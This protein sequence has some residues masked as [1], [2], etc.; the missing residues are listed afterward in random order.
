MTNIKK[1]IAIA[2]LK[3]Q[4]HAPTIMTIA[5]ITG[6]VAGTVLA[7]KATVKASD[8]KSKLEVELEDINNEDQPTTE[9]DKEKATIE[10]Y[11]I[12]IVDYAKLY[13]PAAAVI[14]T[15]AASIVMANRIQENHKAALGATLASTMSTFKSYRDRVKERYGEEAEKS[16]FFN[17]NRETIEETVEDENG[18]TKTVQTEANVTDSIEYSIYARPFDELCDGWCRDARL[19]LATI[20]SVQTWA[21]NRLHTHGFLFLNEVYEAFGMLRTKE[22][23]K[24][25]WIDDG[26][27]FVD[28]GIYNIH[29]KKAREFLHGYEKSVM[30][31]FN[32]TGPILN[33]VNMPSH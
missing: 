15:S 33:N 13:A 10:A 5:G 20:K 9:E 8:V 31:E 3:L 2:G 16:V 17:T 19:N 28:F 7:C 30:L 26:N 12:A 4:Q 32:V 22:G 6:M 21:Q 11:R 24:V 14:A 27:T 1:I 29:N 23:Q 18:N 25:G